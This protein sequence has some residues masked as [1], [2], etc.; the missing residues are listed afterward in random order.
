MS[1]FLFFVKIIKKVFIRKLFKEKIGN[2][3]QNFGE[4]NGDCKASQS[5]T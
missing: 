5:R 3:G 4:K 1:V 2:Q